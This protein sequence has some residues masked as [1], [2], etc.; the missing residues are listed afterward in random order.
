MREEGVKIVWTSVWM[1]PLFRY[2]CFFKETSSFG[3]RFSFMPLWHVRATRDFGQ[4]RAELAKLQYLENRWSWFTTHFNRNSYFSIV[5]F[6]MCMSN[7]KKSSRNREKMR[8]I[9]SFFCKLY[10]YFQF[11]SKIFPRKLSCERNWGY[12]S[13]LCGAISGINFIK[14]C[15][16]WKNIEY[17]ILF[18][19]ASLCGTFIFLSSLL[20]ECCL[21]YVNSTFFS[22]SDNLNHNEK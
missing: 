22:I 18:F 6:I 19:N 15:L 13:L 21:K 16:H 2:A 14:N 1:T 20:L 8:R 5:F 17:V 4:K 7:P 3:T 10:G 9:L 12:F 11:V